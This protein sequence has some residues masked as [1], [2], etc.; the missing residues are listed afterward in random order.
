M[1]ANEA[2]AALKTEAY[3]G[4]NLVMDSI[5]MARRA[6]EGN[7]CGMALLYDGYPRS[8]WKKVYDFCVGHCYSVDTSVKSAECTW[9]EKVADLH[10]L[11][12][13][14][15]GCV[16]SAT[17]EGMKDK[18]REMLVSEEMADNIRYALST[19]T[20]V[21][22]MKEYE[23]RIYK[24][25]QWEAWNG[26][27]Y[28]TLEKMS[29]NQDGSVVSFG[30]GGFNGQ[31]VNRFALATSKVYWSSTPP[32]FIDRI[33]A[34]YQCGYSFPWEGASNHKSSS[35]LLSAIAK[36][37][38]I[39]GGSIVSAMFQ[40]EM[41]SNCLMW[42]RLLVTQ[43]E[44]DS[45]P[46]PY[47]S[48][49]FQIHDIP[50]HLVNVFTPQNLDNLFEA[51]D[52]K[53]WKNAGPVA[54]NPLAS[55]ADHGSDHGWNITA[56]QASLLQHA[57]E[58]SS[59][60]QHMPVSL[61]QHAHEDP[62]AVLRFME[63]LSPQQ[64]TAA[65]GSIIQTQ[66]SSES[67]VQTWEV[68]GL[69]VSNN[70]IGQSLAM[71]DIDHNDYPANMVALMTD[72]SFLSLPMD[73]PK[74]NEKFSSAL[75]QQVESFFL[76]EVHYKK[77]F[78]NV[79]PLLNG[80]E[81]LGIT[82]PGCMNGVVVKNPNQFFKYN[83][84]D[85]STQE[86]A[87]PP[88]HTNVENEANARS[89]S[90]MS[91]NDKCLTF[92]DQAALHGSI[93]A[94]KVEVLENEFWGIKGGWSTNM[95]FSLLSES[96]ASV[97]WVQSTYGS[98]HYDYLKNFPLMSFRLMDQGM[99]GLTKM[100]VYFALALRSFSSYKA[101]MGMCTLQAYGGFGVCPFCLANPTDPGCISN[102]ND[103]LRCMAS[104]DSK[105]KVKPWMRC[106]SETETYC[107]MY[108]SRLFGRE[109]RDKEGTQNLIRGGSISGIWKW[110]LQ[111]K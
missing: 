26:D 110:D 86:L 80:F 40:T 92:K 39:F 52:P 49:A 24:K 75:V 41:A 8:E 2:A 30:S 98:K 28:L 53:H 11:F 90:K 23:D 66:A 85:D 103:I 78:F 73:K 7:P 89:R 95:M 106:C 12:G 79:N 105:L 6:M 67:G 50:A 81:V 60:S 71:V 17:Q 97:T 3:A 44:Q 47:T 58:D 59:A 91:S 74:N 102:L 4:T 13:N 99:G 54:F 111:Q 94:P 5:F 101:Y 27:R 107:K 100:P 35:T 36:S 45:Y 84:D 20:R 48:S 34:D 72:Q 93:F 38:D 64:R 65:L 46:F 109:F 42:K 76:H 16:E 22:M 15:Q 96:K 10:Y 108:S 88:S 37:S 21:E 83:K 9:R 63:K 61:L 104:T 18:V 77:L 25:F 19:G 14:F 32:F 82:V 55:D 29:S 68:D 57:H 69:G 33:S 56:N 51:F 87:C 1:R 62:S 31:S 70:A 43:T